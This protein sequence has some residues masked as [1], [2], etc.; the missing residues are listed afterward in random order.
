MAQASSCP[1]EAEGVR[2]Y[3]H[4]SM[5]AGDGMA[6]THGAGGNANSPLLL[7]AADAFQHAGVTVL[8][9]DLPFRQQRPSGPP[10]PGDSAK[11]RAGLRA[12]V[13]ALRKI[14]SGRIFLSGQSYGG[15]QASMLAAD[16]PDL[17]EAL[18]LLSYP[19]H[20][21]GKPAELRTA[22]FPR[23]RTRALFVQG[24][25][26]PFGSIEEIGAA[27]TMIP[28]PHR[29]TVVEGAGHDLKRGQFDL[30]ILTGALS[31]LVAGA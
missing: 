1:F 29:L 13:A 20:P 11:D 14:V 19:L 12:A 16:E 15:R 25:R 3:L 8:R 21:P 6:L 9:C 31:Q 26:D 7:A 23:L 18:M 5:S 10:R 27:V 2:G 22:H 4:K 24:S 30:G 28:A 17:V